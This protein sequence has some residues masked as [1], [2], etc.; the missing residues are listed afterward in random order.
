M[1][2][3]LDTSRRT[4]LPDAAASKAPSAG[5]VVT[6]SRIRLTS[7]DT[8]RGL[9]MIVMALDHTRDFFA[10]GGFNP[11]DVTDT[12][13]F[14][15]RWV[16]HFCAPTFIF[17]AG[18]SAYLYGFQRKNTGEVSR[19]LL[20]RGLWLVLVEFTVVR[21]GWSFDLHFNY[22]VAQ[23]I[24]A[25]GVSMVALALFVHLPRAAIGF[26]GLA[27]IA[28]HNAFD[29]VKAEQLGAAAPLWHFL[30]QPGL[31]DIAPGVKFFVL[32]PLIPWIGV[33]AAGYALGPV[34]TQERSAR[35]QQLFMLGAAVTL[36]FF[37]LRATN[38]YGDPAPWA[39]QDSLFATVLSFINCEKYPPSLLYL[40][41]T[42]G[43]V[44][45]LVAALER[46]RG[47]IADWIATFGRVPFFYYV[48][49][50]FLLHALAIAFAWA[51]IGDIGW[52]FGSMAGRKPA[53]YGLSL[54]GIYAVWLAVVVALYPL[55]R[56]FAGLKRRRAE[57]WWSYL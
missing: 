40:S 20:T 44:L 26:I 3:A 22:F 45:M 32:Y 14:L 46:V 33:M 28:G 39:I 4:T 55:C 7:I 24:F 48:V 21:L 25:I 17:L 56:W 47:P 54:A 18:I 6:S 35:V 16:T 9:V 34:F 37:I 53:A 49:H 11:R 57:W 1:T 38:L 52:L 31:F 2:I 5:A 36:G 50:I 51:T 23:V 43:P 10:S 12:A 42:L 8:L 27:M 41:M 30:H 15:T 29:G 19:F 13:L